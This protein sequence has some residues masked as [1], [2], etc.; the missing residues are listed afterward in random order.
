MPRVRELAAWGASARDH[1]ITLLI[2]GRVW[3]RAA[4]S[5]LTCHAASPDTN[6]VVWINE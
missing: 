5:E 1:G 6:R 3:H 4:L 2:V